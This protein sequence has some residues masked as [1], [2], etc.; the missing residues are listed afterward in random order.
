MQNDKIS[1]HQAICMIILF[2]FGSSVLLGM[3]IGPVGDSWVAIITAAIL[4]SI[5]SLVYA[6]LISL[7]PEQN[8][9]DIA[10]LV[11]GKIIGKLIIVLMMWYTIHLAALVLRN[12]S[13]FI[14]I[15]TLEET[16]Q[17]VV[18]IAILVVTGYMVLSGIQT[19]G[20]WIMLA[21]IFVV[22]VFLFTVVLSIDEIN[23]SN[24]LPILTYDLTTLGSKTLK[25][26][27]FPFAETVI[28]L[29]L[30]DSIKKSANPY[31]I[32]LYGLFLGTLLLAGTFLRNLII[33]GAPVLEKSYF[34]S[35][36]TTRILSIAESFSRIEVTIFYNFLLGGIS[37]ISVCLFAAVKGA[38]KLFNLQKSWKSVCVI[39][40]VILLISKFQFNSFFEML[41]F[42]DIYPYYAIFFQVIIPLFVWISA[43]IKVYIAH[44][45]S[46]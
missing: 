22:M 44:R 31:K 42:I 40:L 4:G 35:Y 32:Y 38:E 19:F 21:I 8:F 10:E 30:A 36:M 45:S 15:V 11:F 37:K 6:R 43:E 26:F 3:G 16:P 7:F 25:L 2:L 28:F 41:S 27:T 23:I 9:Y 46:L 1:M 24:F 33:L 5:F 13:E 18:M 20:K 17:T 34:P 14:Q 39:T 29:M 12:F